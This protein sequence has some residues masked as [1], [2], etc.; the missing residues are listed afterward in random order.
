MTVFISHSHVDRGL[1]KGFK[2]LIGTISGQAIP[3]WHSSE[4]RPKSGMD[5]GDWR[6]QIWDQ[7][8]AAKVILVLLTPQ[9]SDKP[10]L[11][12]ESG[13]AEGH[14]KHVVPVLLWTK[15]EKMHSVFSD[16]QTYHG[17]QASDLTKLC[18]RIVSVFSGADVSKEAAATYQLPI[19]A[20]LE[21]VE[22]EQKRSDERTLFHDHF[23]NGDTAEKMTGDWIA[24]WTEITED[25]NEVA[26]EA[27]TLRVWS[28][29][30]RLRMVGDGKKGKPYPME[31]VVSSIGQVALSYWSE[32]NTAI[33]G[34]ALMK[35]HGADI[36]T[37]LVGTW[38]GF[39]ARDLMSELRFTRGRVIMAKKASDEDP[40]AQEFIDYMLNRDS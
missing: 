16:R 23:H 27:D 5:L 8:K 22:K 10:W 19:E 37:R 30:T 18:I 40:G 29:E 24:L 36:G 7:I 35:P 6:K 14:S 12:W 2:K 25:G 21:T 1:A 31:G 20:F 4:L 15:R 34:T 38:Q 32:G 9:S 33:C 3:V 17:D 11:V 26:F 39:T 28:D 13:F